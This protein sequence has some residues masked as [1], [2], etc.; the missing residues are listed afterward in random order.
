MA[1]HLLKSVLWGDAQEP[2]APPWADRG[3]LSQPPLAP[4]V[5]HHARPPAGMSAS[6]SRGSAMGSSSVQ[7][8]RTSCVVSEKMGHGVGRGGCVT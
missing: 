7:M 4:R 5:Q 8:G 3:F 2:R 6:P 1:R